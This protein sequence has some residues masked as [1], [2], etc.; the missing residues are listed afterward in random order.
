MWGEDALR[1]EAVKKLVKK[2]AKD[3][4]AEVKGI[5]TFTL[6]GKEVRFRQEPELIADIEAELRG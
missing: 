3:K 6:I 1:K 4:V 5:G 2:L